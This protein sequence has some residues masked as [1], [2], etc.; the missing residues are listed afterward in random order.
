MILE[1]KC[2]GP[3]E[4]LDRAARAALSQ[5]GTKRYGVELDL[6]TDAIL[7]FGI[8]FRGK[9]CAVRTA[10]EPDAARQGRRSPA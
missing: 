2:A 6:P 4:S 9:T 7:R 8:A 3:K 1:L 5:I 10:A